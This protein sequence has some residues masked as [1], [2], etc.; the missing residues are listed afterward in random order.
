M[1]LLDGRLI[2]SASDLNNYLACRHLT[3]L[4]LAR[5][6]GEIDVVPERGADAEGSSS[7]NGVSVVPARTRCAPAEATVWGT[8]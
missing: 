7:A 3:A 4:D 6:R 2:L 8:S 5:A 1:Q